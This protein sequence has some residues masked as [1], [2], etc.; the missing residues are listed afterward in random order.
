MAVAT[1]AGQVRNQ[2]DKVKDREI[3]W[4]MVFGQWYTH[5]I[6]DVLTLWDLVSK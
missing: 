5:I 2:P 6:K 1:D 4:E 3:R